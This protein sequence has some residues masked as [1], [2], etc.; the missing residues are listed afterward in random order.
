MRRKEV[1]KVGRDQTT[2]EK[3]VEKQ[4]PGTKILASL[5]GKI[6]KGEFDNVCNWTEFA[7]LGS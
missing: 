2:T 7:E 6:E 4:V 3:S 1:E 5:K